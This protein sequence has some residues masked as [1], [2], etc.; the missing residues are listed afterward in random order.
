M[1]GKEA[2]EE[3]TVASLTPGESYTTEADC[4]CHYTCVV[5]VAPEGDGSVLSMSMH[6]RG[7]TLLGHMMGAIIL[8]L[9]QGGAA[10]KAF[11]KDLPSR[12]RPSGAESRAGLI[13]GVDRGCYLSP[14]SWTGGGPAASP[15]T[16]AMLWPASS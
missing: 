7:V 9:M 15:R 2:T 5:R 4:G 14:G 16:R 11:A 13:G 3:M 8:P 10:C 12:R 1:F 6:A